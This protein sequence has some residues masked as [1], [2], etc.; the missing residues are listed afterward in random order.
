M[1]MNPARIILPLLAVA[2][3]TAASAARA[4]EDLSELVDRAV[5]ALKDGTRMT[6]ADVEQAILGACARGK[7]HA[8][9]VAPGVI[10][11]RRTRFG[12]DV[13]VMIPYTESSYSIDYGDLERLS[14]KTTEQV[15][16]LAGNIES[17]LDRALVRFKSLQKP[18]RRAKRFNPRYAA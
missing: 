14:G 17:D 12:R 16:D 18:T 6:L 15:A 3:L 11:A 9:V 13:V 8:A 5:P 4:A 7:F 2:L 1:V 10:K